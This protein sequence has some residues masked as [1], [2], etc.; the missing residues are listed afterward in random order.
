M[1]YFKV[2]NQNPRTLYGIIHYAKSERKNSLPPCADGLG[3]S[4]ET[5]FEEMDAV[6]RIHNQTEGRQYKHFMFSFDSGI[7]LP[8]ETLLE[9]GHKIGS[10]FSGEYQ[11]VSYMHFDKR[12]T[13][14]HYILNTVNVFTGQKFRITK[15]D[16]YNYKLYI[17]EILGNYDLSPLTLY[18]NDQNDLLE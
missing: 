4:P 8:H 1:S 12:N 13:H 11:I 16:F 10:Y 9:I 3:V 14:I 17:N 2:I 15:R 18:D 7:S 5:A 6:K